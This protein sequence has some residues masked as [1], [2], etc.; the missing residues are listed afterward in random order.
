M[1]HMPDD[2]NFRGLLAGY[3]APAEEDGFSDIMMAE[4]DAQSVQANAAKQALLRRLALYAA[5]FIGGII[6]ALQ[7]PK[8]LGLFQGAQTRLPDLPVSEFSLA[9]LSF[10]PA[11][12]MVAGVTGFI[13]WAA[14]DSR[15][16]ELF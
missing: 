4:I 2:E 14:L 8:L 10:N 16:S 1:M 9:E 3:V 11:L 13:L 7:L 15:A 12:M 6:A 5:G